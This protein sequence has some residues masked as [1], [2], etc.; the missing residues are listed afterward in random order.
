MR[1]KTDGQI[2]YEA[3]ERCWWNYVPSLEYRFVPFKNFGPRNVSAWETAANAVADKYK[4]QLAKLE[5]QHRELTEKYIALCL[6]HKHID[7]EWIHGTP[8]MV[9]EHMINER[10]QK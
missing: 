8:Q 4:K 5:Q 1:V 9:A 10:N 7:G 3:Y 6:K 2:A